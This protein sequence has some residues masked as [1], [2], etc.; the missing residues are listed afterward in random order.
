MRC[1]T[2]RATATRLTVLAAAGAIGILAAVLWAAKAAPGEAG[3]EVWGSFIE[4]WRNIM[5]SEDYPKGIGLLE[6]ELKKH[7][8]D[9]EVL[10]VLSL[11]WGRSGD[12]AKAMDFLK[13][14][15]DRGMPL[16]RV[17]LDQ[18]VLPTGMT[19]LPEFKALAAKQNLALLAGPMLGCVTADGARFWV[20]TAGDAA[21]RATVGT[22]E[23]LA[24]PVP[25]AEVRS[26]EAD[27]FTAVAE[28]HGLKPDTLYHYDV[29]VDGK[30]TLGPKYP[31]FRTYPARGTKTVV[32]VG[33]GGG[34]R[35]IPSHERMWDA[36]ASYQPAAFL[37]LG[38][39]LYI[40]RPTRPDIQRFH[41]YRRQ[42][43]PEFRRFTAATA[44]YAV[45]DD[46]D[47]G[48]NDCSGGPDPFNPPWKPAV[49]RIF[50]QNWNNP[51]YGGGEKQP[52]CWHD[53]SIGDID[54]FMTDGRYY[55][56]FKDGTM[57]GPVQKKWLLERLKASTATFK[58]L[59]SGTLWTEGADKGGQDSWWGVPE[60]REEVF[61]LI[62]RERIGGVILLS[63]DR[64]RSEVWRID[65]P[66]GYPLYEFE[67]S[68]LTNEHTHP[69]RPQALFSWNKKC[70]F[71]LLTFDTTPADPQVTFEIVSI[72]REVIHRVVLKRS[73]L[74]RK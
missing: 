43:R 10:Y 34:A 57:L 3:T 6:G 72:D 36:I 50:R 47:L 7:P 23:H 62:D 59:A 26:R 19:D 51:Y 9:P 39:N 42:C 31:A 32:R 21:V 38:D 71:G 70:C 4:T 48:T 15:L 37:F 24:S 20:R 67:S 54:V 5:T 29:L 66:N 74:E 53:F 73:D 65:R 69:T 60:E 63:A 68:K 16:N 58:V 17:L 33:F 1:A 64:H 40:D 11:A 61:S 13:Q 14:A 27:D 18:R 49:W 52:G 45:W 28:V 55:R 22:D 12:K 25:S 30:G 56:S 35:Y 2:G 44:I 41:Y 8:D 46:H